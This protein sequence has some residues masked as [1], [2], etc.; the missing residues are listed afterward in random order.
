[1]SDT[2][3]TPAIDALRDKLPDLA[4]DLRLN[5]QS[6]LR[7]EKLTQ[8]QVWGTALASAYFVRCEELSDALLADAKAADVGEDVIEDAKAAAALMAMNTTYYRFRHLIESEAYKMPARLRMSRM[9]QP[10]T[11]KV[12]FELFAMACAALSGCQMCV[13]AHEASIK[14]HGLSEEHV[15]DSVRIASVINGVATALSL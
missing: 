15:H 3:T 4:K 12:D 13:N 2:I 11:S 9:A 14:K 10:A 1:M 5:L 7:P 8:S 6:V